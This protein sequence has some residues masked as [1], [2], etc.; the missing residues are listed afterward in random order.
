MFGSQNA[1]KIPTL[2]PVIDD[3]RS[4]LSADSKPDHEFDLQGLETLKRKGG[5]SE[6]EE[7]AKLWKRL[8]LQGSYDE[9]PFVKAAFLAFGLFDVWRVADP[10][11]HSVLDAM[12]ADLQCAIGPEGK[13]RYAAVQAKLSDPIFLGEVRDF[14]T[15]LGP[16]KYH[17]SYMTRHGIGCLGGPDEQGLGLRE[18][19]APEKAW[20]GV[21]EHLFG[22]SASQ[23]PDGR[24]PS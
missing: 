4:S 3:P 17:P 11:S 21:V 12:H 5:W 1:M 20:A 24:A 8:V 19:V 22:T 6:P 23:T 2:Q 9:T 18:D 15:A 13:S 14:V 16:P 10:T 7:I